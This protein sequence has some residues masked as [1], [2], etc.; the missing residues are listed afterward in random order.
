MN[1]T[2]QIHQATQTDLKKVKVIINAS[3]PRF[4]RYFA[5]HSVSDLEEPTIVL[6]YDG[7]IAGFAKLTEFQ[8]DAESFGCILW[9]AVSPEY[10]RKGVA[11]S[12]TKASVEQMNAQGVKTVFAST[13]RRNRGALGALGKSG[14]ERIGLFGLWRMFRWHIFAFYSAIWY[15][16]G[17]V[18]L[19]HR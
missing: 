19:I 14:F 5:W 1:S 6:E 13:Q 15:A 2:V 8:I 18:V 9:V 4:F 17:E 10:R 12:L 3:F 11:Y 7:V 16:P